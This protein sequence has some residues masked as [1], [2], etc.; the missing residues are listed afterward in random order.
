MRK[1]NNDLGQILDVKIMKQDKE[2]WSKEM[3]LESVLRIFTLKEK[4]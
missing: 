1:Y 2:S 3:I 4:R